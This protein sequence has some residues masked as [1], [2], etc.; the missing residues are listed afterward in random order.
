MYFGLRSPSLCYFHVYR[1][2]NAIHSKCFEPSHCKLGPTIFSNVLTVFINIVSFIDRGLDC[3]SM[4]SGLFGFELW[5]CVVLLVTKLG[6]SLLS[7]TLIGRLP[8]VYRL[9]LHFL[10]FLSLEMKHSSRLKERV[11]VNYDK[12][13]AEEVEGSD[14]GQESDSKGEVYIAYLSAPDSDDEEYETPT[15]ASSKKRKANTNGRAT[16]KPKTTTEVTDTK[17]LPTDSSTW[18]KSK[19]AKGETI[20]KGNAVK[21]YRL[22]PKNDFKELQYVRRATKE[23][24]FMML[25]STREV[26]RVAWS[27]HGSPEGFD[28]YLSKLKTRHNR[29][30]SNSPQKNA[31]IEPVNEF[32]S[33]SRSYDRQM[34]SLKEDFPPLL[35]KNILSYLKSERESEFHFFNELSDDIRDKKKWIQQIR[36]AKAQ[37]LQSSYPPRPSV[38]I[39]DSD[40]F[41]TLK[42]IL[43]GAPVH[44][45][46]KWYDPPKGIWVYED[47]ATG[48]ISHGWTNAFEDEV[49]EAVEAVIDEHGTKYRLPAQWMV[50]NAHV[51]CIGGLEYVP[52]NYRS[53]AFWYDEAKRVFKGPLHTREL[54]N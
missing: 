44:D 1:F 25:Y 14:A 37:G 20:T 5:R 6:R 49:N 13:D 9:S 19:V 52:E 7:Q 34:A 40:S 21:Q 4:A 27:K 12:T 23:G 2:A 32:V 16:K 36:V 42:E 28:F 43:E 17:P 8:L 39:P 29:S 46:V 35:W 33:I 15:S 47:P 41:D 51:R 54:R 30:N 50:Y 31:F 18:R 3:F 11:A 24:Y 53:K 45:N 26:E 22:D 10:G 48:D 38:G